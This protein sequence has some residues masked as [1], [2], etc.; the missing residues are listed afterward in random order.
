MVEATEVINTSEKQ[1]TGFEMLMRSDNMLNEI[2]SFFSGAEVV[3]KL[4]LLN[5]R[6]RGILKVIT[7]FGEHR[8]ITLKIIGF[9]E[10][11]R[12]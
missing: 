11:E 7:P 6:I 1:K 5:K 4:A 2:F 12:V 8:K 9:I 3:H 10:Y